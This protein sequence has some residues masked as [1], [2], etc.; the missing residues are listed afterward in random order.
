MRKM[1][2]EVATGVFAHQEAKK[3]INIVRLIMSSD[4]QIEKTYMVSDMQREIWLRFPKE[5]REK[6]A[7]IRNRYRHEAYQ[8]TVHFHG[9]QLCDP[10]HLGEVR[11]AASDANAE[12]R[13]IDP[14]L[15]AMAVVIPIDPQ[16][17]EE[18]ELK[19]AI[20]YAIMEQMAKELYVQVKDLKSD[21]LTKRSRKNMAKLIE[22]F[23][24]LNILNDAEIDRKIS[25]FNNLIEM[26][27]AQLKATILDELNLIINET[28]ELDMATGLEQ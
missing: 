6:I 24:D 5:V 12:L 18:G 10:T 19:Q 8:N 27:V 28:R 26:P 7:N 15:Y 22:S 17:I 20:F 3:G 4:Q 23:Y 13:V 1:A 21:G 9:L 2:Q 11:Q 14:E 16:V 25:E